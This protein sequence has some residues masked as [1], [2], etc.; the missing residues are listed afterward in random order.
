MKMLLFRETIIQSVLCE[1]ILYFITQIL[2]NKIE[3]LPFLI[4]SV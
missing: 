1:D 2:N 4:L 3:M